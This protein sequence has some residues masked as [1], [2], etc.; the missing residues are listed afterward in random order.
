[1]TTSCR[2]GPSFNL[3]WDHDSSIA[4]PS[5]PPAPSGTYPLLQLDTLLSTAAAFSAYARIALNAQ[6]ALA[7]ALDTGVPFARAR[8]RAVLWAPDGTP[9]PSASLAVA[10]RQLRRQVMIVVMARDL[11]GAADLAEV[12]GTMTALAEEAIEASLACAG[13]ELAPRMGQPIG[14]DSGLPQTLHVVGMG[15]LGGGELNV[16]SDIDLIFVYPEEGETRGGIASV[17]NQEYFQELGKRVIH[18][19]S[20]MTADGYVFRVDMR[21]RPWGDGPLAMG[22]DALENYLVAHGRDWERYAWIKGRAL[23]GD[24]VKELD[25]VVRP[26]VFRRYLDFGALE[27]LRGLHAQIKREVAR[28]DLADHVKLGRAASARSSSSRRRCR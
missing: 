28:R 14:A 23:S 12:T 1:M 7:G 24:R 18:L 2:P 9:L 20:E 10:L 13:A 25:E 11:A 6:P 5:Q 27:S 26:F 3:A 17:P 22:F 21:L 4:L 8:M 19:L 16:S 15:K